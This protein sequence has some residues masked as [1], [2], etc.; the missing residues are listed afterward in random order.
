MQLTVKL[1][2]WEGEDLCQFLLYDL[3]YFTLCFHSPPLRFSSS[4]FLLPHHSSSIHPF[5][6]LCSFTSLSSCSINPPVAFDSS[7][8]MKLN[9]LALSTLLALAAAQD[10]ASATTA[11]LDPQASCAKNC[12]SVNLH[13]IALD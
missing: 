10:T 4:F 3:D 13:Q 6:V 7:I 5:F 2:K 9:L 1:R 12:K 11:S 8:T